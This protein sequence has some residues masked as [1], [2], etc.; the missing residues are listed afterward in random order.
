VDYFMHN[1]GIPI[2]FGIAVGLGFIGSFL[3]ILDKGEHFP[4]VI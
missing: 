4:E 3:L 2:N 1:T